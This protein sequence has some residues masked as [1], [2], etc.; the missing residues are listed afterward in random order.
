MKTHVL[1]IAKTFPSGHPKE[2]RLTHFRGKIKQGIKIHTIREN[3]GLWEQRIAEVRS[4]NAVLS[5]R[6]WDGDPRRSPQK[7]FHRLAA[8]NGIG[9]Q[10]I[11]YRGRWEI[12]KEVLSRDELAAH[13]GLDKKDFAAWFKHVTIFEPLALIHF[14]GFRYPEEVEELEAVEAPEQPRPPLL[15]NNGQSAGEKTAPVK[16]NL[17]FVREYAGRITALFADYLVY[18]IADPEWVR[19]QN[20]LEKSILEIKKGGP[21]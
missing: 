16:N 8:E 21:A 14:T 3:Y 6:Q 20:K 11:I 1:M 4:G 12:G 17:E 15:N 9:I 18:D 7:E 10:K 2:G 19:L 5:L 13:D